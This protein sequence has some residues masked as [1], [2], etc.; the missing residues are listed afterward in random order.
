MNVSVL[1]MIH[2]A[3]VAVLSIFCWL[4]KAGGMYRLFIPAC[5][6]PIFGPVCM[7]CGIVNRRDNFNRNKTEAE[8][9][10]ELDG[11]YRSVE[12]AASVNMDS[13]LPI[14]EAMI[15][16][17]PAVRRKIMLDVLYA[18]ADDLVRPIRVAGTNDDTE[19]VHYAVTALIEI[20]K[21]YDSRI[22]IMNQ[23]MEETRGATDVLEKFIRLD[24]QYLNSGILDGENRLN[25]LRH[26][27]MLLEELNTRKPNKLRILTKMADT[28]IETGDYESAAK[29][30]IQMF[31]QFPDSENSYITYLKMAVDQNDRDGIDR[32]IAKMEENSIYISP[33]NRGFVNYWK[34]N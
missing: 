9:S 28:D 1:M 12:K 7:I 27:R 13:I 31:Q 2:L 5:L 8:E 23:M 15:V 14:E 19:V 10:F 11:V 6:I 32:L 33:E 26:Y 20:R 25:Q 24:E 4:G 34:G 16:N 22:Q 30:I 29:I 21:N 17:E 3:A 18:G